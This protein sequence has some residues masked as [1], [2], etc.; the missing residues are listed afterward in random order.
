MND[1]KRRHLHADV[2][3]KVDFC[4]TSDDWA[5]PHAADPSTVASNPGGDHGDVDVWR[6]DL[7]ELTTEAWHA[8]LTAE[9]FHRAERFV[10]ETNCHRFLQARHCLRTLLATYTGMTPRNLALRFNAQGKPLL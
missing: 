7:D 4:V 3:W 6:I 1:M 8:T 2:S 10:H 9:E 5:L